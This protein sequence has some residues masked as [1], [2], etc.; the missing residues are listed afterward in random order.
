MKRTHLKT[1]VL[2]LLLVLALV[3]G[4][5]VPV[6]AAGKGLNIEKVDGSVSNMLPAD[7]KFEDNAK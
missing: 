6:S 7:R 5:A 1:R 4:F 2:S 3:C